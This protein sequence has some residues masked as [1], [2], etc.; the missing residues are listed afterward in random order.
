MP[1]II[2]VDAHNYLHRAYHALPPLTTPDGET[3]HAV[4][5]F[6]RTLFKLLNQFKPDYCA[7]CFDSPQPSFRKKVYSE[8]KANR[9]ETEESLKTQFPLCRDLI[10]AMGLPLFELPGMEADDIIATLAKR[11]E[12]EGMEVIAISS[13]KDLLQIVR[14]RV[15]VFNDSKG[16]LFDSKKV[17]EEWGVTPV[18][19]QDLLCLMGD[20][21]DNVPGVPGIGEKTAVKLIHEYKNISNLIKNRENLPE[22]LA[23]NLLEKLDQ[24][25]KNE[26]L[27]QLKSD[28]PLEIDWPHLGIHSFD[29]EKLLPLLRKWGFQTLIKDLYSKG[30]I[31][32]EES[33]K[34]TIPGNYK[35]VHTEEDLKKML[36]ELNRSKQI[37]L[38]FLFS[39]LE[40]SNPLVV[41]LGIL[42][43][44]EMAYYIP[45]NHRT[46]NPV[47]QLKEKD[48]LNQLKPLLED[49]SIK[50]IFHHLKIQSRALITNEIENWKS[51]FD[52]LIAAY[53]LN[54][55]ESSYRFKNSIWKY[56]GEDGLDMEDLYELKTV[57]EGGAE[58]LEIDEVARALSKE[59]T[60]LFELYQKLMPLLKEKE[61]AS[62]FENVEMPLVRILS[63]M[64]LNGIHCDLTYLE[65]IGSNFYSEI[66]ELELKAYTLAGQEFNLNSSKQL[67]F[68]LFEKLGLPPSKKKKTQYSTDEGVLNFLSEVH[69]LPKLI[70]KHRE[71]SKLKSTY[72][73]GLL[74]LIKHKDGRIHT[75]FNQTGTATGRLSSSD[76]N[77]QN[78]PIRTEYGRMIR[79]A[80][81]PEKGTLFLAG[82]YS[83]I[84][85]RVLAHLSQDPTMMAAFK[86]GEDIH[87]ATAAEIY[88]ISPNEVTSVQRSGAKAINF[89]IIYG[90][91]AFGLAGA[92]KITVGEAQNM[93]DNYFLKYPGVK[94]W[95][96]QTVQQAKTDGFVK[97]LLGHTRILPEIRS[98]NGALR[99]FGERTAMNTPVQGTSAE[100]IKCAM[101]K[102]AAELSQEPEE[103][104]PKLLLQVHD[105][106]LFEVEKNEIEK[107]ALRIKEIMESALELS[108]PLQVDIKVGENW[109]DMKPITWIRH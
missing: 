96:D 10:L 27:I 8:Y 54:P 35:C 73:D 30:H 43:S 48:V 16:I 45:F 5:G 70:L 77:L 108:V 101:I 55:T 61:C 109:A 6:A 17:E 40:S 87:R 75:T 60:H 102:V 64:E 53:T 59:I 95:I 19:I 49:P 15:Q 23:K 50:K 98:K 85:L 99:A 72:V 44:L 105:D 7:V 100:I 83:Q 18:Q 65:K 62:L 39:K 76:P 106:L 57:V 32:P 88:A 63:D 34:D 11:A 92:L 107:W 13:D 93:I 26:T 69:E 58:S 103:H 20:S 3:I 25:Q 41:G 31:A 38:S 90:Q 78:I 29:K 24:I 51:Y 33:Q 82:D 22:K 89:G 28:I 56:L 14:E 37:A 94:R 12:L 104:R 97:T 91:Q 86:N 52:C 67:S 2:L 9:K 84:D 4:Y 81:I 46:I 79:R 71:L 36:E 1:R 21:S 74:A 47:Q 66:H 42:G 68:I 80:F